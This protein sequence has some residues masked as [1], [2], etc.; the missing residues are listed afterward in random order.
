[1]SDRIEALKLGATIAIIGWLGESYDN[2]GS[3]SGNPD[4]RDSKAVDELA[5]DILERVLDATVTCLKCDGAGSYG[6]MDALKICAY[7]TKGRVTLRTVLE[8]EP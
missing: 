8:R 6:D 7:C 1:M 4:Y 2:D 3:F 5:T